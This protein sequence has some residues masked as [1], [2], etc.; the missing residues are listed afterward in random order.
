MG[1]ILYMDWLLA[2]SFSQIALNL[3]RDSGLFAASRLKDDRTSEVRLNAFA[4]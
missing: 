2:Y 4:L 3:K 1:T